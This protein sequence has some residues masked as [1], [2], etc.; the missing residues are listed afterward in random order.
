MLTALAVAD[1]GEVIL[2]AFSEGESGALY[3]AAPGGD[4]ARIA[5]AVRVSSIAFL[6]GSDDAVVSD[7]GRNEIVLVRDVSAGGNLQILAGEQD[8]IQSPLAVAAAPNGQAFAVQARSGKVAA[9]SLQGGVQA[10]LDCPCQPT[11]MERL[12]GNVFRLTA[13]AKS[14]IYLLDAGAAP[15]R[16]V[17]VPAATTGSEPSTPRSPRGRT[18][19]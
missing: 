8:G 7:F 5:P 3:A 12:Q 9:L 2:A 16:L 15:A 4:A 17:F 19:P 1:G 10:W 13:D 14:P 6:E 11:M 18:R